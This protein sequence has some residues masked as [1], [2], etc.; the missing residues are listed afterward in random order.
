MAFLRIFPNFPRHR[1]ARN[2]TQHLN[3]KLSSPGSLK[4]GLP[5]EESKCSYH[6]SSNTSPCTLWKCWILC[7]MHKYHSS[8]TNLKELVPKYA[9]NWT[10]SLDP[11]ILVLNKKIELLRHWFDTKYL[12]IWSKNAFTVV[13]YHKGL[14]WQYQAVFAKNH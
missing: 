6:S 10:G 14:F 3:L 4:F 5:L 1:A 7:I 2:Q 8:D 9:L 13:R 12:L 11:W